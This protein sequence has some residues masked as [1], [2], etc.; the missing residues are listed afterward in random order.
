MDPMMKRIWL[1]VVLGLILGFGL[2]VPSMN[3]R[4]AA[5]NVAQPSGYQEA[6][7]ATLKL[8]AENRPSWLGFQSAAWALFVGLVVAVPFF[9]VARRRTL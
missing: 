1:A 5:A 8:R 6:Q 2:A 7:P 3:P 9:L 4:G